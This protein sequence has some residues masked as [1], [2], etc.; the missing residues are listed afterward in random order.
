MRKPTVVT[1]DLKSKLSDRIRSTKLALGRGGKEQLPTC[2]LRLKESKQT[3]ETRWTIILPG[4]KP[5]RFVIQLSGNYGKLLS[6]LIC[7]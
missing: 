2:K 4:K 5:N 3:K 1:P 6:V 7:R